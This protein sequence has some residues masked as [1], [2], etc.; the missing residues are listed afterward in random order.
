M[1]SRQTDKLLGN[2]P[3][4][5][6]GRRQQYSSATKRALVEVATRLFTEQGYAATS[7]D[8]IVAGAQVT[9]GALYHHYTGKQAL[10]EAVFEKVEGDAARHIKTALKG[11]RDPWEKALAGL[12]AFLD[13]V[14]QPAYQR[15]VIQ[16]GP[17]ILGYE[18]FREQEERSSYAIVQDIVRSVLEAGTFELGEDMIATFSRIFFGAMS[19]A[20]ETVTSAEDPRVAVAQV[21]T[22]ITFILTGL[23]ALADSGVELPDPG[24]LLDRHEEERTGR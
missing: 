13:V 6:G 1:P 16:E 22:A 8:A 4:V 5:K 23:R 14:Q 11:S 20:G 18:R 3:K 10:F 17:A 9:K 12:R 15:V 2:L 24:E 21:E 7:L 19:A